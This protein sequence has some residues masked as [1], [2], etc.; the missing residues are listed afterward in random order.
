VRDGKSATTPINGQELE[1]CHGEEH[2]SQTEIGI[3]LAVCDILRMSIVFERCRC[4]STIEF[5]PV[6]GCSRHT[7]TT[8]KER[9]N[10]VAG[11]PGASVGSSRPTRLIQTG[12]S[13]VNHQDDRPVVAVLS[14]WL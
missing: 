13:W 2:A 7:S 1:P 12:V 10:R 5:G 9:T 4:A 14:S 6:G 11:P 3:Y 8:A